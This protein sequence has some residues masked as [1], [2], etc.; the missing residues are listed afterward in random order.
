M[1]MKTTM[2]DRELMELGDL[3]GCNAENGPD[4]PTRTPPTTRPEVAYRIPGKRWARRTFANVAAAER[5]VEGL[6][7][8]EGRGVEVRWGL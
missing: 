3:Y 1:T 2:K 7:E 8:R 4:M 6:L 5:F